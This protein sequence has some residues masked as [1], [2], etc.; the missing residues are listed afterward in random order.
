MPSEAVY[1]NFPGTNPHDSL[2]K[3]GLMLLTC[4]EKNEMKGVCYGL[5]QP[6]PKFF[7]I[8]FP[9]RSRSLKPARHVSI[10]RAGFRL[11]LVQDRLAEDIRRSITRIGFVGRT[12]A[13][14][15][16]AT[17][18]PILRYRQRWRSRPGFRPGCGSSPAWGSQSAVMD[19][20]DSGARPRG[21]GAGDTSHITSAAR[22]RR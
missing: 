3:A 5:F 18:L 1:G 6:S 21:P 9:L 13:S 15:G 2:Q 12:R 22:W 11:T 17:P 19:G 7:S 4:V 10:N 14:D 8:A 16:A 20:P